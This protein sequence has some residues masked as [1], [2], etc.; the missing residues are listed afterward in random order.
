MSLG[1][2]TVES[3]PLERAEKDRRKEQKGVPKK[4]T[5][6]NKTTKK[7]SSNC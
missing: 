5:G 3:F 7:K 1:P 6:S 4:V 2:T